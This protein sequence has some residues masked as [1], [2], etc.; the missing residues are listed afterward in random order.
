MRAANER[1]SIFFERGV[2]AF[3]AD[4]HDKAVVRRKMLDRKQQKIRE[5]IAIR[6]AP[7]KH[8]VAN[9]AIAGARLP[10]NAHEIVVIE[11]FGQILI[12]DTLNNVLSGDFET[13]LVMRHFAQ[14]VFFLFVR[15]SHPQRSF[16]HQTEKTRIAGKIFDVR[17]KLT[18]LETWHFVTLRHLRPIHDLMAQIRKIDE[19]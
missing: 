11:S 18:G 16:L 15:W 13:N 5:R 19:G 12:V 9:K 10:K 3:V 7:D 1:G 14:T 2:F 4:V 6:A 17:G 8:H